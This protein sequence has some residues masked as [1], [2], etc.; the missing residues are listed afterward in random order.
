M[1]SSV[2]RLTML[3]GCL[4]A[5]ASQ[6]MGI[7]RPAN[8]PPMHWPATQVSKLPLHTLQQLAGAAESVTQAWLARYNTPVPPPRSASYELA[9]AV[10]VDASGNVY[11]TGIGVINNAPS[12]Y[13]TVKYSPSGQQL[14]VARY[15][16]PA[17]GNDEVRAIAVD[18]AGNAYVTGTSAGVGT[19]SDYAT[20]KY[21]PSGQEL[22][23][24]RY[25]GPV[26]SS[27][28][29]WALAL[30]AGGNVYVAGDSEGGSTS[31]DFATVKYSTSGQQLWAA[32][33]NRPGNGRDY[34]QALALDV[35][36]DAYV[37]GISYQADNSTS[38]D[39]ATVKYSASGQQLWASLYN[40]PNNE[41]DE[42]RIIA[43]DRA[44]NAYVSGYS[45]SQR[46]GLDGDYLTIKY[47]PTGQQLWLARYNGPVD[48]TDYPQAT[49]VD[50]TGNVYVTGY[51]AGAGTGSD[52]A[53]VKYSPNG[54][55][56]W[57]A[58][59]NGTGNAGDAATKMAVDAAGNAYV[60]GSST[61]MGSGA[62]YLTVKYS[63]TGQEQWTTRYN[64]TSNGSD[65]AEGIALDAAGNVLVTG[66]SYGATFSDGIDFVTIKYTQ[67][68]ASCDRTANQPVAAPDQLATSGAIT[69]TAAQLLAN[70]SDPQ[71]RTLQV[72]SVKAPS[73]GTLVTNPNGTYTYT[74]PAG[75][76]GNATFSYLIAEAGPVLASPGTEHYYEFVS[77]P[78]ICWAAAQAAASARTYQGMTGYLATITFDGEKEF[79]AGRAQGQYW[80]GA[81]DDA[82]EGEWRWK[83]GPEAGQLFWRGNAS[84]YGLAYTN[85]QPGQ[86]DDF[87][88]VY[89]PAGEDYGVLYGSS[90]LWNDL[91]N[92]GAGSTVAGYLVEYGGLEA[93]TPMLYSF[94]TVTV[95][96]GPVT[97][98]RL[99][100]GPA[101]GAVAGTTLLIALPN[102]SNGQ[103][104]VQLVAGAEGAAQV[105]LYDLQGRRVRAL[106]EGSLLTNEQRTLSVDAQDLAPGLYTVRFQNGGQVQHLRLVIQK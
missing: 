42:G 81:A 33:Y 101:S 15:N 54:Q 41:Y 44:G 55:Q 77:A 36:G 20:V 22:W 104:Q 30:D 2:T 40:S 5:F 96:V 45:Y 89:R 71:G 58:R 94:G 53:T 7:P 6:A 17:N 26:N 38:G 106:F 52:Y 21:S 11:V 50:A 14:W 4:A 80:F 12:D 28:N 46:A 63:P 84:G 85:W 34:A 69:F 9:R 23:V 62:D 97:N 56:L 49:A 65:N 29:A 27:E 1:S 48:G 82:A 91:D 3:T 92:C 10:A 13:L 88:N 64:G 83:T 78:G 24:N 76:T 75:F 86:P 25:N 66:D 39:F 100:N 47:A 61:G 31:G 87:R 98:T 67:T 70:D 18:A 8:T 95:A 103:F 105:D 57:A 43:V 32:R 90:G 37:T 99:A 16:G 19:G 102:P 35:N 73:T 51:S 60:T 79:L 68:A 74:P 93:C 59:Y 72:A